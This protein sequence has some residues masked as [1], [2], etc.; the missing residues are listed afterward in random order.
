MKT[1]PVKNIPDW[2]GRQLTIVY[3]IG[4]ILFSCLLCGEFQ[5]LYESV[6]NTDFEDATY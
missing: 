2:V 3:Q 1:E 5:D 6:K 4:D